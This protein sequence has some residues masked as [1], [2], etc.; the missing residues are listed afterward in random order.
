MGQMSTMWPG[1]G[2]VGLADPW[3]SM[4]GMAAGVPN[5]AAMA[6]LP[7]TGGRQVVPAPKKRTEVNRRGGVAAMNKKL[8]TLMPEDTADKQALIKAANQRDEARCR[9]LLL[10][11]DFHGLVR[12]MQMAER[13]CMWP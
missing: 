13:Y 10:H 9:A 12:R 4:Y 3:L 8:P 2:G 1:V 7:L 11:P 5:V 6:S